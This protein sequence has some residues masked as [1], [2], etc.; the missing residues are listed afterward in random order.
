MCSRKLHQIKRETVRA[1][2][3]LKTP[4]FTPSPIARGLNTGTTKLY[5]RSFGPVVTKKTENFRNRYFEVWLDELH[6]DIVNLS[7]KRC[8]N[9][10]KRTLGQWACSP[11]AF[12]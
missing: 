2:V 8:F 7:L 10:A 11:M 6:Q 1:D 3:A 12:Y 4:I 5:R 9:I